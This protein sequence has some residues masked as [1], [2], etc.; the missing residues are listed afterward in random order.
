VKIESSATLPT[1]SRLIGH[2]RSGRRRPAGRG[3]WRGRCAR[4]GEEQTGMLGGRTLGR[5]DGASVVIP[6]VHH[7]GQLVQEHGDPVRLVLR[8]ACRPRPGR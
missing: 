8:G 6:A 5:A 3:R 2:I 4:A 1:T 7:G